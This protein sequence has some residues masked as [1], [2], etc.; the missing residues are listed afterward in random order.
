MTSQIIQH[1][2]ETSQL[3]QDS[4]NTEGKKQMVS[5]INMDQTSWSCRYVILVSL[6]VL[7]APAPSTGR[8]SLRQLEAYPS[9]RTDVQVRRTV[10]IAHFYT[11][12]SGDNLH[13]CTCLRCCTFDIFFH[14]ARRSVIVY[15]YIYM[16]LSKV[17]PSTGLVDMQPRSC[18]Y[19][20]SNLWVIETYY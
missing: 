19:I 18:K 1:P 2:N 5:L 20:A 12:S 9:Q 16:N 14:H 7:V 17:E 13:R 6:I 8:A 15:T 11:A 10:I 4:F 3:V